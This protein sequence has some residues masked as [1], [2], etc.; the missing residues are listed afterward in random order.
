MKSKKGAKGKGKGKGKKAA[1]AVVTPAMVAAQ[2]AGAGL[3]RLLALAD[4][5]RRA[6]AAAG[7]AAALAN[8][9]DT[10]AGRVRAAAK[11]WSQACGVVRPHLLDHRRRQSAWADARHPPSPHQPR[12]AA[13]GALMNIAG[14]ADA[15][16]PLSDAGASQ[17]GGGV[18]ASVGSLCEIRL[19][20]RLASLRRPP[21]CAGVPPRVITVARPAKVR[22]EM[23]ALDRAGALVYATCVIPAALRARGGPRCAFARTEAEILCSVAVA[24]ATVAAAAAQ[25]AAA[26][27]AA[28]AAGA[29][30]LAHASSGGAQAPHPSSA[31]PQRPATGTKNLIISQPPEEAVASIMGGAAAGAT[32]P[33]PPRSASPKQRATTPGSKPAAAAAK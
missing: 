5:P 16:K 22:P 33:L 31:A 9:V 7:G 4:G 32:V 23:N 11:L 24:V 6:I 17:S 18:S 25:E 27:A 21:S 14:D 26:G 12:W 15:V 20:A 3:L 19:A 29:P 28:A 1:K 30:M 10:K 8:L 2:A 13:N